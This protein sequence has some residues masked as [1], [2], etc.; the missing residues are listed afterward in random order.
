MSLVPLAEFG[1]ITGVPTPNMNLM[2]DLANLI[3]QKDYR[4]EGR[5]L[6]RLGLEGVFLDDLKKFV[7]TGTP[8][9]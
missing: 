9:P 3:H 8:L 2:I 1:R 5:T 4:A 7:A 6:A